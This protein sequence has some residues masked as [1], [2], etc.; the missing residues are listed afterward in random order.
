MSRD[1]ALL[2]ECR[3]LQ[4]AIAH[5]PTLAE[6]RASREWPDL[7][8]RF[9]A[10]FERLF[11][12]VPDTPP[13]SRPT[14]SPVRAVQWNIEHGNWYEPLERALTQ[15][16]DLR[17]TDLLFFNEIDLGMARAANRDV[18]G[19][20]AK[21]LNR[22]AVWAPLFLETTSG[23]DDDPIA[24]AGRENQESL[25]GLA[26]LSRWPIGKVRVVDFPSP[27]R[28]QFELER[29]VGRHVALIAEIERPGAPFVAVSAH[30]EVHRTRLEREHQMRAALDALRDE[31]RPIIFAGDWNTHTF[32]RGLWH[33]PLTG[34]GALLFWPGPMLRH[35]L[36]HPD[37]GPFHE[38]LFDRLREAGFTWETFVDFEPTLQVRFDRID[39]ARIV[40]QA[41]GPLI[42]P[43]L[44]WAERRGA[45]RLDWFAA[46]GWKGGRGHTVHGL[47]GPGKASD[48]APIVAEFE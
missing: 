28:M 34:A 8:R 29:M 42:R 20:L 18:T 47:D 46:R 25:F 6:L 23:R 16:P 45:L 32:D 24:A 37:R 31:R 21:T 7:E 39:E 40:T 12:Y 30:L 26:I 13:S 9:R 33:S 35:R 10:L 41:L 48:H 11:R 1:P 3:A 15:Q 4:K 43:L 19:D 2:D 5:Y 44:D 36:R 27:E 17:D 14:G 22:Y 38:P